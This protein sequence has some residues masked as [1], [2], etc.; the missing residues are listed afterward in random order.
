[1]LK[2]NSNWET[3]VRPLKQSIKSEKEPELQHWEVS[4][5]RQFTTSEKLSYV[6]RITDIGI[7]DV[8]EK[9]R[10]N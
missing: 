10:P 7:L 1:M 9:L 6:S 4:T 3:P 5:V 8:G 2:P